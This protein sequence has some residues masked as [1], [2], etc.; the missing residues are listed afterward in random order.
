[1]NSRA[2]W[3]KAI[4]AE[5]RDRV[6]PGMVRMIAAGAQQHLPL[7]EGKQPA[8]IYQEA[9]AHLNA[10]HSAESDRARAAAR[11]IPKTSRQSCV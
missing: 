3:T 8:E 5:L 6:K 11:G 4:A 2:N 9:L 7:A 1:M 10:I